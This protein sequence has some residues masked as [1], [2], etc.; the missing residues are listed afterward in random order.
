MTNLNKPTGA[1]PDITLRLTDGTELVA[2]PSIG[3]MAKYDVIR[4]RK[5]WPKRD[6]AEV[7]FITTLA[8]IALRRVGQTKAT[9]DE[10]IESIDSLDADEEDETAPDDEFADL[11]PD[12]DDALGL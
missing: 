3:D 5:G 11:S 8:W 6:D 2:K 1:V 4:A 12:D 7:L 9:V 10:F